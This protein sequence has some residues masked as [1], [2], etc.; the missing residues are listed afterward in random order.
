MWRY[1]RYALPVAV[2]LALVALFARGL[3][4]DPTVVPS[5]LIGKAAPAF[6]LPD[7]ADSKQ[8]LTQAE[9]QGKVSLLNVWGSWCVACRDEHPV[10]MQFA[11]EHVIPIY[12]LDYKDDRQA[13]LDMLAKQ[14]NPYTAVAYDASGD[15]T[16]D[17]GVYGAPETF[18]LDKHGIIRYKYIGPLTPELI[19]D[20]LLRRIQVLQGEP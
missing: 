20:D 4:L 12:G 7:L 5:P 11:A 6:S 15:A 18:L 17:W 19:R 9:L 13:A 14:G 1:L 2:L 8:T 10:L 16:I 3:F